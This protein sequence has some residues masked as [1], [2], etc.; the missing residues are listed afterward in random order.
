VLSFYF[1]SSSAR[2]AS[3][4]SNLLNT[5]AQSGC[6]RNSDSIDWDAEGTEVLTIFDGISL[7]W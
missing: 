4:V 1:S 7:K 3:L 2:V 6:I 5:V